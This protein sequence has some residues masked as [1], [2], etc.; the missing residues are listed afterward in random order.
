MPRG[1][2]V[3]RSFGRK[4]DRRTIWAFSSDS[5]ATQALGAG[6][7]V[8][9][10]GLDML[11]AFGEA[12]TV[13]RTR[14]SLWVKSDQE[15]ATESPFGAVGMMVVRDAAFTAGVASVPS[16]IT[17][18]GDEGWFLWVPWLAGISF[19]STIGFPDKFREYQFDVK[20]Q[21]KVEPGDTVIVVLENAHAAN[22][23]EY[24]IKFRQLYL[25]H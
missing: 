24:V 1:R 2:I 7:V 3:R 14:G 16:P 22:G 23:A 9:D 12:A 19:G 11:S 18:E 10:Q 4:S 21:R 15:A 13:V 8:L 5:S 20:A 6:A 25:L 17:E